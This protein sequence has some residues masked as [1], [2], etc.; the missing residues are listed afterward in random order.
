MVESPWPVPDVRSRVDPAP[1]QGAPA[2][3]GR[4]GTPRA[5]PAHG[6]P[7]P[8]ASAARA[9][10]PPHR[11][12]HT[13][14]PHI[15]APHIAAPHFADSSLACACSGSVDDYRN[16]SSLQRRVAA[17]AGVSPSLVSIRVAAGSVIITATIG[18]PPS[19]TAALLRASLAAR[20]GTATAASAALG[21]EVESDPSIA[22]A[23]PLASSPPP[24]PLPPAEC[25]EPPCDGRSGVVMC[26]AS[27]APVCGGD[28]KT[29]SNRCSAE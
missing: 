28:G 11:R 17:V 27:Y 16:T 4:L 29:Y 15:A 8:T 13:A 9:S 14:A 26:A 6:A 5:R 24:Q 1:P 12:P 7:R 2:G 23:P 22:V 10:R 19:A 21:V 25:C 18:V 20:L 3:S